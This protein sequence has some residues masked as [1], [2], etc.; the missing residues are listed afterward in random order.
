MDDLTS[1]LV[2][3]DTHMLLVHSTYHGANCS[4]VCDLVML[5]KHQNRNKLNSIMDLNDKT[6]KTGI[7]PL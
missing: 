7:N 1:Y 3:D 4:Q 5:C 2:F 6:V